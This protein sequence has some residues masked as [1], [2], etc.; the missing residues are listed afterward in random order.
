MS[1]K[2]VFVARVFSRRFCTFYSVLVKVDGQHYSIL[3][4]RIIVNKGV[5]YSWVSSERKEGAINVRIFIQSDSRSS[6]Y[7]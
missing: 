6:S 1:Y 5:E 4:V 2:C 3:D 7:M